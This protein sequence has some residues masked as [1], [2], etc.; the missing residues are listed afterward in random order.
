MKFLL[1]RAPVPVSED[2]SG[3][4]VSGVGLW[5]CL[6]QALLGLASGSDLVHI[7]L[8]MAFECPLTRNP[9]Y[10]VTKML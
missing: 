9:K 8:G 4:Q 5:P 3:L 10:Y 1:Q 7:V 6:P 2:E